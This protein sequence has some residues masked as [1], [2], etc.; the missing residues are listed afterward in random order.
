MRVPTGH[1]GRGAAMTVLVRLLYACR[2][3]QIK[4]RLRDRVLLRLGSDPVT[5]RLRIGLSK[6][7]G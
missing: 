1:E 7:Y 6:L 3:N 5:V 4:V 2:C